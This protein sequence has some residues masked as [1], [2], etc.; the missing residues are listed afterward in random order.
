MHQAAIADWSEHGGER[1]VEAQDAGSQIALGQGHGMTGTEGN[2]IEDAAIL[3]Q[4][5]LAIGAAVQVVKN[6]PG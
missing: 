1:N 4:R 6:R 2:V 5:D 3:A